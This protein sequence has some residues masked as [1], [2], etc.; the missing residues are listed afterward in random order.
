MH[1]WRLREIE[2]INITIPV[3]SRS[4]LSFFHSHNLTVSFIERFLCRTY[5]EISIKDCQLFFFQSRYLTKKTDAHL[6]CQLCFV[7]DTFIFFIFYNRVIRMHSCGYTKDRAYRV[8]PIVSRS[9]SSFLHLHNLTVS[10]LEGFCERPRHRKLQSR[11]A[12]YPFFNR[13]I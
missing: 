13:D 5:I 11:I 10:F 12:I 1:S 4:V 9:F 8:I 6:I 3:A 7:N 2:Y